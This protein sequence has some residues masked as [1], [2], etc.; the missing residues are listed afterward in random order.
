[1]RIGHGRRHVL[2]YSDILKLL[3]RS[4]ID[5]HYGNPYI[6]LIRDLFESPQSLHDQAMIDHDMHLPS[7][8]RASGGKHKLI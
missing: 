6:S 2:L 7:D 5:K 3:D 4:Q 1:M 8:I